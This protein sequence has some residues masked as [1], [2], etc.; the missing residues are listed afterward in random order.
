MA[1]AELDILDSR[2]M[3]SD[4]NGVEMVAPP[5]VG[6]LKSFTI[7]SREASLVSDILASWSRWRYLKAVLKSR[8]ASDIFISCPITYICRFSGARIE[9]IRREVMI[10]AMLSCPGAAMPGM[11]AWVTGVRN[12]LN[13]REIW[14]T[15]PIARMIF[16][17]FPGRTT[18]FATWTRR[19]ASSRQN[20]VV[21][22]FT[23]S[24]RPPW[25]QRRNVFSRSISVPPFEPLKCALAMIF[26]CRR[27]RISLF[28]AALD[29]WCSISTYS[30]PSRIPS[31]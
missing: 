19:I 25:A 16:G 31:S 24:A 1:F 18:F 15:A 14:P 13:T 3:T 26:E 2:G 10:S 27:W 6:D 20:A 28:L 5:N 7:E 30:H 4:L 9:S 22:T 17:G 12:S 8:G 21:T 23:T 29:Q 11:R